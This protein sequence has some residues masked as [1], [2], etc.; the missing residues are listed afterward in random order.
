MSSQKIQNPIPQGGTK[1]QNV[2]IRNRPGFTSSSSLR[3]AR[4]YHSFLPPRFTGPNTKYSSEA[5]KHSHH[6]ALCKQ[7]FVHKNVKVSYNFFRYVF[8]CLSLCLSVWV[9]G[10]FSFD[11]EIDLMDYIC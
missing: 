1:F 11:Y 3:K 7:A 6:K 8:D 9:C 5:T 10:K 4:L 2:E